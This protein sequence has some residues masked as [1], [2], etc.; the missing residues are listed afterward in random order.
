MGRFPSDASSDL[1]LAVLACNG[2]TGDAATTRR[3]NLARTLLAAVLNA[4][5]GNF[6][7]SA[8]ARAPGALRR[9]LLGLTETLRDALLGGSS[10][11][12]VRFNRRADKA[13]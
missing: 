13:V 4:K 7:L 11:V 5:G 3:A 10:C 2:E 12:S 6:V 1:K 8:S 9:E